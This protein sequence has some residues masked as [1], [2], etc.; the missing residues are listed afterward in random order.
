VIAGFDLPS[1][2]DD[3]LVRQNFAFAYGKI[4]AQRFAFKLV[5]GQRLTCSAKSKRIPVSV[6]FITVNVC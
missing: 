5:F 6:F 1:S 3:S 4:K 2:H